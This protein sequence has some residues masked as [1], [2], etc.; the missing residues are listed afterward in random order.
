MPG[1]RC[2]TLSQV[3]LVSGLGSSCSQPLLAK[4]PSKMWDRDGRQFRGRWRRP[5]W[6]LAARVEAVFGGN[7]ESGDQAIV[8]GFAPP[9]LEIGAGSAPIPIAPTIS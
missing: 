2:A 7:A 3:S 5:G 1:L 4:R 6:Q 9:I 8:D